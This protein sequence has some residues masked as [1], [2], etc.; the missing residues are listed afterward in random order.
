MA[1]RSAIPEGKYLTLESG[2]KLHYH[3]AGQPHADRPSLLVVDN[4]QDFIQLVTR[5][6]AG[7]R[8]E[9]LAAAGVV[10]GGAFLDVPVERHLTTYRVNIEG[11]VTMTHAFL[12]DLLSR[13]HTKELLDRMRTVTRP[14][15]DEFGKAAGP[16][17][18]KLLAE[19]RAKTGK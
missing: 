3:E 18:A 9:V 19:F 8:W 13:Q 2:L 17:A 1:T 14:M 6:L 10:F 7:H 16:D 4:H 5:Y 11:L 12:P 15:W